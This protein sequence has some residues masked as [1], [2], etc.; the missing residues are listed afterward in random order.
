VIGEAP[1]LYKAG[2]PTDEAVKRGDFGEYA[3]WTLAKS[4]GP[5][6]IRKVYEELGG[7]LK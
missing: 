2:V 3:S 7:A 4:Q 5:I 6:A 1:R